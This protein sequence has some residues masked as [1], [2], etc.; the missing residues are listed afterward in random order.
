MNRLKSLFISAYLTM[1][2]VGTARAF[3]MSF[4][5]PEWGWV[6]LALLFGLGFFMWVFLFDVSRTGKASTVMWLGP[7]C[8]IAGLITSNVTDFEI[9][10]W[11]L[12]VGLFGSLTYI[13]WYSRFNRTASDQLAVGQ[14]LPHM[15]FDLPDGSALN[16]KDLPGPL[17]LMFYRGNWCP[18]CMAQ[19]KEVAQQYQQLADKGVQLLMISPQSHK[20]TAQLAG[21]FD[22]PMTFLVDKDLQEAKRLGIEALN[23]LPTGLEALGYDS[24][25]VMPTVIITDQNQNIIFCDQTDNYRVRPEPDT[26]IAVLNQAGI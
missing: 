13:L 14:P 15:T 4:S 2:A 17:L 11:V 8:S 16:T 9:W 21:R 25:T 12:D 26:F 23:G 1:L 6:I 18:L 24:D 22:V 3:W 5:N 7:V 10:M 19:I 20:N